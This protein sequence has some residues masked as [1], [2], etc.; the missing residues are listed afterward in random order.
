MDGFIYFCPALS[1]EQA[2]SGL[3]QCLKTVSPLKTNNSTIKKDGELQDTK[4]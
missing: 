4:L 2:Q 1:C 3:Q